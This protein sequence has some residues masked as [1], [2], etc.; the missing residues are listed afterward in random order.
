MMLERDAEVCRDV[1]Q[2]PSSSAISRRPDAPRDHGAVDPCRL[3]GLEPIV[4]QRPV[5]SHAI[6]ARV[7]DKPHPTQKLMQLHVDIPDGGAGLH[8]LCRD[9]VNP[10]IH[11]IERNLGI[12]PGSTEEERMSSCGWVL[13][14]SWD[15]GLSESRQELADS[16][17]DL[18]D[19]P[20]RANAGVA[21]A[22]G[23]RDDHGWGSRSREH[24]CTR[25]D[26]GARLTEPDD[27][28]VPDLDDELRRGM[29][30]WQRVNSKRANPYARG[31]VAMDL[32]RVYDATGGCDGRRD[33]PVL[34]R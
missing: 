12:N 16:C 6:E 19:A 18:G 31:P 33:C 1:R 23:R 32:R 28:P 15:N 29:R 25:D 11:G 34:L 22:A 10:N 30:V 4:A 17:V 8:R 5:Q 21:R 13:R 7:T 20:G 3:N 14:C 26:I 9:P 24:A 2:R 27:R